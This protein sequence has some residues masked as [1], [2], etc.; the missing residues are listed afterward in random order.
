[1]VRNDSDTSEFHESSESNF[2]NKEL[3]LAKLS[4]AFLGKDYS[5]NSLNS[6]G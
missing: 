2:E 5:V 1:V 4:G 6:D 3:L